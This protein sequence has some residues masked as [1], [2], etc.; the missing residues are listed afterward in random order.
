MPKLNYFSDDEVKGLDLELTA[1]LDRARGLAGVPFE[2]AC[3]L[4]TQ[5]ENDALPESV[6]DSAH[7]TGHAVDLA[8]NDSSL[9]YN[10][11]RG[12]ILAGF[13]RIGVYSAHLHADNDPTL[14]QQTGNVIWYVAGT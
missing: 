13:T 7:L 3:G 14:Q 2:I 11:L 10:M 6:K 5:A 12:L 1:M 9:R 8:C 4:R